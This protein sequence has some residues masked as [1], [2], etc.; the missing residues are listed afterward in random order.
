MTTQP[1]II[2]HRGASDELAEHTLAA[3]REAI[4]AGADALEC[5]VR[6]TADT[7]L[8]CVHDRRID[9][10]SDG[11]G[12]VAAQ[13][14]AELQRHDFGSWKRRA[15]EAPEDE[16]PNYADVAHSVLTLDALIDLVLA[17]DRPLGLSI[18][19]KH[20]TR[21]GGLVEDRLIETLRERGLPDQEHSVR[22]M[23]FAEV[24]LRRARRL[25]PELPRVLLMDRVPVRCRG[26]W[27]PHG[28]RIAGPSIRVLR[29]HPTYVRRVRE[30]GGRVHVW[31]VD[32]P[33][34]VELC[35]RLG[36]DAIITNRPRQVRE[37]VAARQTV[38]PG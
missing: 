16:L 33:D 17:T 14:L 34:D 22:I 2:A 21:F 3:Y 19:T 30:A 32:E 31:T 23:S 7:V 38:R 20:P 8:V 5:D 6:L 4:A 26:G 10:T 27:L 37:Q 24:A 13:T 18:E 9:R 11:R 35:L 29:N 12:V 28:A 25:A 1:L 15:L 36:V